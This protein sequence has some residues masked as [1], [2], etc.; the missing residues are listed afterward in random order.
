MAGIITAADLKTHLNIGTVVSDSTDDTPIG[1]AVAAANSSVVNYCGR[2]FETTTTSSASARV[3]R[4]AS[5]TLTLTDDFWTTESLTVKLATGVDGTYPTSLTLNTDYWAE[6]LNGLQDGRAVPYDTLR[7]STWV[8]P[9]IYAG[10]RVYP[11]VQVTAAWGWAAVPD[12][13]FEATLIFAARL[14]K[15]RTSPEGIIGGF[16]DFGAIRITNRQ[17]PDVA[18]LLCDYRSASQQGVFV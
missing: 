15:R 16:A 3:Y 7:S 17:D 13:V 2:T 6:P 18:M 9:A 1:W 10:A 14:F 11:S 4:P 5:P 8:F 12:P